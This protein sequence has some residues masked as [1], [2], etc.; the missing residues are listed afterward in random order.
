V[1]NDTMARWLFPGEDPIGKRIRGGNSGP[2]HTIIGVV[3]DVRQKGL[4]YEPRPEYYVP[5]SSMPMPFTT[6]VARTSLPE[7][8]ALNVLR[9][10]V[11]G[12]RADL[13][14]HNLM[15]L[16][17]LSGDTI[18]AR[19][20]ALSQTLLFAAVALALAALGVYGVMS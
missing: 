13:A 2:W 3:G 11:K 1:I 17:Q 6:V 7:D 18:S 14:I 20:L 16:E 19:R 9:S 15:P 4:D 12:A 10:A 5:W 8:A